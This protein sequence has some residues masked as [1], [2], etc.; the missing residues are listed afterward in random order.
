MK[1][2]QEFKRS[3]QDMRPNVYKFGKLIED[4]TTHPATKRTIEGHAQIFELQLREENQGIMTTTSMFSG[5]RISRYLSIMRTAEDVIAN[6]RMKRLL[7]ELTGTCT[8]GRCVGWTALNSMFATSYD[9]DQEF[10][11]DYHQRL[12]AWLKDAQDRDITIA[13][14]LTDPKGDRTL[15]PHKQ[16]NPDMALRLVEMREDGMIVRGAK[17]QI[18]GASA[19]NEIFVLPGT[20]YREEDRDYA[21]S[22]VV[23][24]DID[25][26]T[27]VEARHPSDG[28]DLESGPDNPVA[29]GGITQGYLLFNDVFVPKERIFMAGEYK[30]SLGAVMNFIM[31]YRSAIGGCVAGQGDVMAGAA[32]LM[33]RANGIDERKFADKLIKMSIN[34]ETTF[35]VGIAAAVQ[36][37]QHPSGAWQCDPLL[38]NVNKVHVA[39]L[40]Y[41]TKRLAQEIGGGIA[42]TGCM[43][44]WED[45]ECEE[46][47]DLLKKYLTAN[48]NVDAETRYKIARLIEWLTIGCG[49]PGCMHGGGSPDGAK[50]VIK[51]N[52]SIKRNMDLAK[53][54]I[55]VE[56]DIV[57]EKKR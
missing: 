2:P 45:Y 18:A 15:P 14:A 54:L 12:L 53:R 31:T 9:I 19:A 21:I 42:E 32:A 3:L 36:G 51:G 26:L 10:G 56:E 38:A 5:K 17:V 46:Y 23:P 1:T 48:A 4:V 35:A 22:F 39:T 37:K 50:L 13:G 57:V 30:Y 49:V 40:P 52:S 11:T 24:R 6:A 34:N 25:G 44:S 28:R 20:G 47:G 7:F 43:P 33:S 41:E 16:A 29:R 8:G 27:V 55:G